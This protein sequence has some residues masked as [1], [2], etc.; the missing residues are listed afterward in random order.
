M[1]KVKENFNKF[2]ETHSWESL[3]K[4]QLRIIY[5]RIYEYT[6]ICKCKCMYY[7]I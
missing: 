3:K 6:N 5:L 2:M 1:N 4:I 7:N